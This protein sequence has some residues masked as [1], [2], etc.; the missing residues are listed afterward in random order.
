MNGLIKAGG[1][2]VEVVLDGEDEPGISRHLPTNLGLSFYRAFATAAVRP[3]G[4]SKAVVPTNRIGPAGRKSGPAGSAAVEPQTFR[5][6][7]TFQALRRPSS[8]ENTS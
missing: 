2:V 4:R 5:A 3:A 1:S 8:A 6:Y 7:R